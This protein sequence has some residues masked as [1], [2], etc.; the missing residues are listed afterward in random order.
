M[1]L[2]LKGCLRD[3][4]NIYA[5]ESTSEQIFSISKASAIMV[6]TMLTML[7]E[8]P[9]ESMAVQMASKIAPPTNGV[10]GAHHK[11]AQL[12]RAGELEELL[13]SVKQLI[14]PF[15]RK[16]DDAAPCRAAGQGRVPPGTNVLVERLEPEKLVKRLDFSLPGEGRGRDGLLATVQELLENSVN[17]WDQGFMDKLYASTNPV[18]VISELILATLNT[19]LHVCHVSPA[20][21]I[22]EKSTAR[23][24]ASIMGFTGP[25]AG[26]ITCPG[27]S[28]S[29]MTSLVI[30]RNTLYPDT[31]R[32]GNGPRRLVLFTSVHSHYSIEKAA[33]TMGLGAAGTGVVLVPADAEGRM[34]PGALRR[35]VLHAMQEGKTPFYVNATAGTT[36]LGAFD[37]ICEI[38]AV[39]K[40][41]GLWLHVDASWGGPVAFSSQQRHKIDGAGLA[42]SLTINPHKMLGAPL[43]CSFLLTNDLSVFHRANTLPAGYLFHSESAE[44]DVWDLADLTLQCGRRGDALKL[45]LSWIYY[46][47]DGFE[48]QINHAFSVA[49]L[50]ATMIQDHPDFELVSTNPPPCLQVCFYYTPGGV[51]TGID[52][53]TRRTRAMITALVDRGF[54]VDYAPGNRGSFFRV[55]VNCQTLAETV[56]GL[57]NAL[58]ETGK[59]V[60][61]EEL[62]TIA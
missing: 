34:I 15:V 1:Q 7:E 8:A 59:G 37:P 31:K 39:C 9:R 48:K 16:A 30:A 58:V 13:D 11:K 4:P 5:R 24:L 40:E 49:G 23:A 10:N 36:V 22:V 25:R 43:P 18:G 21:T 3:C 51:Q 53:N 27:G 20:L 44:R 32:D 60:I 19:A 2:H 12:N 6:V 26:G 42:D 54:M 61:D 62:G 33:S 52:E 50:L 14:I 47:A 35:M 29:N 28:A 56:K 17:T 55:V 38:S 41:F 46:G 45:A 57:V